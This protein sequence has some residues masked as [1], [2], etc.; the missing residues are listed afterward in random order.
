[1]TR[2]REQDVI[3]AI[4]A[5]VD[6]QMAGGEH[7]HLERAQAGTSDRCALCGG[8]WHGDRWDG[9]DHE[10]LGEY[11]QHHHGRTLGCPGA[12]A[13]GPQRIRW[14]HEDRGA[15][16]LAQHGF[17]PAGVPFVDQTA[18][19]AWTVDMVNAMRPP[20]PP[21][22]QL[23]LLEAIAAAQGDMQLPN[24]PSF[25]PANWGFPAQQPYIERFGSAGQRADPQP[26]PWIIQHTNEGA[27]PPSITHVIPPELTIRNQRPLAESPQWLQD[28]VDNTADWLAATLGVD[29]DRE[30]RNGVRAIVAGQ[31]PYVGPELHEGARIA[32][33]LADGSLM[34]GVIGTYDE[35]E[36]TGE[37]EMT[38]VQHPGHGYG[39]GYSALDHVVFDEPRELLTARQDPAEQ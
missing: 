4:D 26:S 33:Q 14:R 9:V 18:S 27:D 5:L 28:M 39:L 31:N 10:H 23:L 3:D 20:A 17:R 12:N 6:E 11:D 13:T 15:R 1:M 36:Q 2:N 25:N 8:A 24:A 32:V 22:Q 29:S 35:N 30:W 19:V 7:A 38:L 16:W 21:W 34:T 37:I